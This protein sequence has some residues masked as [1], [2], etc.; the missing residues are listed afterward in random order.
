MTQYQ[1]LHFLVSPHDD[2]DVGY[3]AVA[4]KPDEFGNLDMVGPRQIGAGLTPVAALLR[5]ITPLR[6]RY[7][8]YEEARRALRNI[9]TRRGTNIRDLAAKV[10]YT[11]QQLTNIL[12]GDEQPESD[13]AIVV[14]REAANI[15]LE[16]HQREI[17]AIQRSDD[18]VKDIHP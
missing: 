14:I 10:P 8:T 5:V 16:D 7:A 6:E 13:D 15:S 3:T 11:R 9:T 12:N 1:S 4:M 18:L 2:P 17:R